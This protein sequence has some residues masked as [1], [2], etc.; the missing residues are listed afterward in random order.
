MKELIE[1]FKMNDLSVE[2]RVRIIIKLGQ[3][4]NNQFG[5]NLTEPIVFELVRILDPENEILNT[6]HY[7][8]VH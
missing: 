1:V 8:E 6:P 7:K 2:T 3:L 5:S 4:I